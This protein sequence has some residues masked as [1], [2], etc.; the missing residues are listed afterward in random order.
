M[1]LGVSAALVDGRFVSG[2]VE[3]ADGTITGYGLASRNGRGIAAPGFVD[4]QVNGFGGVD[5]LEADADGY[6]RAGEALLETGVT[7]YLPTFISAPEE[8][9]IAALRAVPVIAEGPRILGVPP[10][11]SSQAAVQPGR[12]KG[13]A[14]A[15]SAS[16][17]H[18]DARAATSAC[19]STAESAA[20]LLV[21][22]WLLMAT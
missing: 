15:R 3:V 10:N 13:A 1:R 2:D 16:S 21:S 5:L 11:A 6:R 7:S 22:V 9:L 14:P 4:L 8:D 19:H 20:A 17:S 18:S 12:R